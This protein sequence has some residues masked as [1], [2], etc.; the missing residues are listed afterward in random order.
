MEN[1]SKKGKEVD[2]LRVEHGR[3]LLEQTYITLEEWIAKYKRIAIIHKDE[4]RAITLTN[5]L[6]TKYDL[7]IKYIETDKNMTNTQIS[8][9][10]SYNV[11][12]TYF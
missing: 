8:V 11:F 3:H 6:K 9:L 10:A 4:N 5:H 2:I 7:S 12:Y 1:N